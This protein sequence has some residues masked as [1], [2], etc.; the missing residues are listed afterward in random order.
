[1]NWPNTTYPLPDIYFAPAEDD[2]WQVSLALQVGGNSFRWLHVELFPDQIM[3]L[4]FNWRTDPCST[5]RGYWNHEP[6]IQETKL[7]RSDKLS[8]ADLAALLS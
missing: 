8:L 1:M 7:V 3:P 6:P 2:K 5:L 4:L